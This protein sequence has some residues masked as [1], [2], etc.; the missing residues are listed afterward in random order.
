MPA[1]NGP[2]FP[3]VDPETNEPLFPE[4]GGPEH[5]FNP[6]YPEY[7]SMS[8]FPLTYP[9]DKSLPA[10]ELTF[11]RTANSRPWGKNSPYLDALEIAINAER[12]DLAP[13]QIAHMESP[14]GK[15]ELSDFIGTLYEWS[16]R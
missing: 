3:L 12:G 10:P 6:R 7:P 14:E 13:E 11:P 9:K 1:P 8:D 2:Q 5:L 4:Y 15:K 16:P